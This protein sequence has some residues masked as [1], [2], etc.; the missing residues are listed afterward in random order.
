MKHFFPGFIVILQWKNDIAVILCDKTMRDSWF[1]TVQNS[2]F[3]IHTRFANNV[4]G[5][6]RRICTRR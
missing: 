6:I 2:Q 4:N 1:V 3:S 5:H